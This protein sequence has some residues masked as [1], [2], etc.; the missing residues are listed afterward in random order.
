ML[1]NA[2]PN[3]KLDENNE[4]VAIFPR[5]KAALFIFSNC[6]SFIDTV[7]VL[8]RDEKDPDDVNT[9]AEDHI[10]DEARYFIRSQ[11]Q[12]GKSGTTTGNH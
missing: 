3:K 4:V 11:G 6:T 2:G 1:K 8:P 10:A 12:I 9:D 7:P 5:E